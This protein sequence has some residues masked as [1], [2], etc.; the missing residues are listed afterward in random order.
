MNNLLARILENYRLTG[1][2][3]VDLFRNLRIVLNYERISYVLD[4][5][6]LNEIP[7]GASEADRVTYQKWQDDDL[8]AKSYILASM[9]NELQRQH[10]NMP[11]ASSM[12]LHLQEL[13]GEQ[14]R[15]I[16]YE[17]SKKLFRMRMTEGSVNDHVLKMID[18]IE[19]LEAL[20]FSMDGELAID[21]ILQSLPDSFS[22]FIMNFNMNKM[23]C[24]LAELL[25]M[26]N[27]A[28]TCIK[29]PKD[30][31]AIEGPSTKK[32]KKKKFQPKAKGGI[33]KGKANKPN[34]KGKCFHCGK[35]GHWKRNC[36]SY[37]NSL[38][39]KPK[40]NPSE[41]ND[42]YVLNMKENNE[43]VVNVNTITHKREREEISPKYKWH[44]RLGHIGEDRVTKLA[45]DGLI[46]PFGLEPYPTCESCLQGKM[47]RAPF[48][49]RSTRATDLL[50]L[51]HTDVCGPFNEMARGG[52]YYFIT[53]IDDHSRYSSVYLMKYKSEAFEK[54]KEYRNEV[55]KQ[56]GKVIK[57]LRSD[58]GGEYLSGEF[59][60]YLKENGIVSQWTPP[61]T[62]ELNG[63]S[64]RRNRTL[65]PSK[66]VPKIPYEMWYG[67]QPSLN[68]LRIWGCPA[69]IKRLKSEKLEAKADSGRDDPT[70]YEEA[71]SDI[72][73]KKWL[74]AMDL[75]MDSMRTNQVWTL[76]DP[77]EGIIPIGCKWI[78]KRKIG[79]DG[80]VETYKAR[81]VAKGYRQ[82]Q[83]IDY[84]ETFSTVA[85][86]KSIRILLAIA[87]YYDYEIWQ[88]DVKTAFLNGYI[89]EDI[90]MIQPC[91]FESKTNPHKVCKLRKSIYGL[92][93]ASRS[94][95]IRF[96]DA[97]KSFGFI[98]N[99]DE[100]CVYKRVSGSAISFLVLYVDDILLI[101]N[102]I[103]QMSSVKIWLSQNFS[104]KDLGDAMYI[105]GI[106]IYRDRS[107]K[108]IGLCQ[109]K[110]IEKIL[111]KFNM[112]DSKRGFIPFRHGIH[113][114]KS[115]SPKTYD[116]IERMNKI[117]YA[118]A[119][120]S[121]MYAMLC[122]R[123]DIAQCNSTTEAKYIVASDAA[124][125][126][127]WTRKFI[128]QLEVVPTIALSISLYCDNNGAIAQAKEPRSH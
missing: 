66:S 48:V 35:N 82:I 8:S 69:F 54:F 100:P 29:K 74:E 6:N 60:S 99:E 118:S 18:Y 2:N 11:D 102:D 84:E 89:E 3:Y 121:L 45:K 12:I 104:M 58:R 73:S 127:V 101:G 72:D 19:Q 105:L 108:L 53:F 78:F 70:S 34:D 40:E 77:P 13:Y 93:Q 98:K 4:T 39:V 110:Y 63:V 123:P 83:S 81:L 125:E 24:S 97:I 31:M 10:E 80:K 112:W 16:R 91:G 79:L 95:N 21:L 59:Q 51:I 119:I 116:E 37:L 64:E 96:D 26:L 30:V 67:K 46:G 65:V 36:K 113:L 87:A 128:Q 17:I 115:M 38:K 92:K 41:D 62:P 109:A 56:T 43:H 33:K 27:T 122:T 50:E 106:R 15:T 124:K 88:M 14:S 44:L 5:S 107:R 55:E 23:E 85:M 71:I 68:H 1:P 94:W 57:T 32:G 117:P 49:G 75:E 47:T 126:A 120:G 20:N 76:V 22:Q 52:Y 86:L 42:L 103:G 114:S 90:Y 25:K 28:E 9:S 7:E 61:G 111:K